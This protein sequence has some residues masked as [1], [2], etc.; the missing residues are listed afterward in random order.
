MKT[1][2]NR[3][4]LSRFSE[5]GAEYEMLRPPAA[6]MS[7]KPDITLVPNRNDLL[8]KLKWQPAARKASRNMPEMFSTAAVS[9]FFHKFSRLLKLF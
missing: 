2:V 9:H 4:K 7:K 8:F 1:P 5:S 6:D 3:L